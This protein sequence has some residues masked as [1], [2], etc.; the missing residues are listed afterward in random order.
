MD[1]EE[2]RA[3]NI[4]E[5]KDTQSERQ[6]ESN[7]EYNNNLRSLW[8]KIKGYLKRENKKLKIYLKK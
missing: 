6:E 3:T 8:N 7:P 4:G 2:D 1:E 5:A